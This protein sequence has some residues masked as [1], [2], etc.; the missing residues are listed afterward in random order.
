MTRWLDIHRERFY[1]DLGERLDIE[2]GLKEVLLTEHHHDLVE[3][4]Q[5]NL[6]IEGGL[7][8]I[9][10]VPLATL[11]DQPLM[12]TSLGADQ[13]GH[14]ETPSA[15]TSGKDLSCEDLRGAD[16]SR[17]DLSGADLSGAYLR[18]ADL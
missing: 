4:I 9:L 10:P 6:D 17:A 13:P 8:A 3:K 15:A 5:E 16:L 12:T 14:T 11:P 2:A 7:A 1:A 18:D